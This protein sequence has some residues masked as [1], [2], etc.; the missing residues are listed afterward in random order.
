VIGTLYFPAAAT[1]C[2]ALVRVARQK[3]AEIAGQEEL[4]HGAPCIDS[5]RSRDAN[6][7]N[8]TSLNHSE[9]PCPASIPGTDRSLDSAPWRLPA[10][11]AG[12]IRKETRPE[13]TTF[14]MR[15]GTPERQQLPAY[16]A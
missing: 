14:V 9:P 4:P 12:A 16:N 7:M 15:N 13:H 10:Q 11:G 1:S 2:Y 5:E 6:A 3:G 8:E